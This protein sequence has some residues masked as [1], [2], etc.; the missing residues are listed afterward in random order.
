MKRAEQ[1]NIEQYRRVSDMISWIGAACGIIQW[2]IDN[3]DKNGASVPN[4]RAQMRYG[5]KLI[6]KEVGG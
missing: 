3:A 5:Q 1:L 6:G 4:M 2:I